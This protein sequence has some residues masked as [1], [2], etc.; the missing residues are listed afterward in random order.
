MHFT[1]D[2]STKNRI[3]RWFGVG[4]MIIGLL[5]LAGWTFEF[6]ILTTFMGSKFPSTKGT[7]GLTILFSSGI[8]I[9]MTLPI[10]MHPSREGIVLS[11]CV[12]WLLSLV[13]TMLVFNVINRDS[14][15]SNLFWTEHPGTAWTDM[16]GRP[17]IAS[18]VASLLIDLVGIAAIIFEKNAISFRRTCGTVILVIGLCALFGLATNSPPLFFYY[19]NF[20]SGMGYPTAYALLFIGTGL[21]LVHPDLRLQEADYNKRCRRHHIDYDS[22]VA[23]PEII[24]TVNQ[25]HNLPEIQEESEEHDS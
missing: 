15:L 8:L 9:C 7:A 3:A 19:P 5:V 11:A 20:S 17:S 14:G 25:P 12:W 4:A 13:G 21:H 10:R 2:V 24:S 22:S 1:N 23:D 18:V 6:E 16:P